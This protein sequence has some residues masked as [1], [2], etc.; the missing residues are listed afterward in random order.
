M[1]AAKRDS[2][3]SGRPLP[4]IPEQLVLGLAFSA[5]LL[6]GAPQSE[7]EPGL[8][9]RAE[10]RAA[11]A[12]RAMEAA[13][14]ERGR[15]AEAITSQAA[16]LRPVEAS[17]APVERRSFIDQAIFATMERDGVPHARLANDVE[18]LRRASIDLIGRVPTLEEVLAFEAEA[19]PSKRDDLVDR[20][21][22]SDEFVERWAYFFEDL[23]RAGNRMGHGKNLFRFWM[24]EWLTLDRSYADVVTDLL[25]Q[26]G[27]SSHSSPGALYFA[28]D[29]V[30]AKDDPDEADAHD[31]V[32]RPDSIDEFTITYGKVFLGVN[33]GCISCHDGAHHLEQVNLF[34]TGKT[35]EDFFRQ[36]AF[37]GRTRMIMNWENGFQANTEYTV[38]DVEPGYPTLSESIVRVPRTG[39]SNAPKFLLDDR[40]PQDGEMPR[41]AL[42]R[43]LTGHIQFARA[44]A[45]RV[46]AELMGVGIVEPVDDFDLARYYPD[47]PLPAGW[48]VQPS[49]PYLLD[50]LARDFQ[51]SGFSFRH[52]VRTIVRSSAY[53][54][55]SQF[56]GEWKTEYGRYFAR[57]H[58]KL[59]S[60]TQLHDS[61]VTAT[62]VPGAYKSGD[63]QVGLARQTLDPAYVTAEVKEF[64]R[65]FGQ[66]SRDEFP[67]RPAGSSLQAMLMMNSEM[68]LDRVRADGAGRVAKLLDA[69]ASDEVLAA[70]AWASATGESP[71]P[72]QLERAVRRGLVEKLYLSTLARRPVPAEMDVAL[73]ALAED[74]EQG[75]ENLQ[76]ALLNKPE[77]LF[78]F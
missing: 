70:A 69:K 78:N 31:L 63:R 55:S 28:R 52:L 21:I 14:P 18:F 4:R 73:G 58:V 3:A 53:Q 43:L 47:Q 1:A 57:R 45:N 35:R 24:R 17:A 34:L 6:A 76:W 36:A 2:R 62:A 42:A 23:F 44:T 41:D 13:D 68:V 33:L 59:L 32:N 50:E 65:A 22:S 10:A 7:P 11:R 46:W 29:F 67:A 74:L 64:L 77:F 66:Q 56:D 49:H 19:S 25:T 75:A 60:P 8:T 61:I 30:K 16:P 27:K 37:F 20:L 15:A 26:G 51:S 5:A 12:H 39:G 72:T 48:T 9:P 71:S 40:A 54:L 38:D